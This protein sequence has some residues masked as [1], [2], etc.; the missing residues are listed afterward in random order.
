MSGE[1]SFTVKESG[2]ER[3]DALSFTRFA[4]SGSAQPNDSAESGGLL[5]NF[6]TRRSWQAQ[7]SLRVL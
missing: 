3:A 7:L 4:Q 2:S 5:P 6:L 1:R